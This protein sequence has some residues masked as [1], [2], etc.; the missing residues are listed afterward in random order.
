MTEPAPAKP[1]FAPSFWM[2]NTIEMWERLAYY[3]L[4][5]M[6]PIYIMQADDPGGLHLTAVEQG[7]DLRVVGDLPIAAADRH[8]RLRRS[9]RLQACARAF[10]LHDDDRLPD[11]RLRPRYPGR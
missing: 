5:V 7:H 10:H 6:A 2:L 4:R 3:N 11:E 8:G 9:L 1:R